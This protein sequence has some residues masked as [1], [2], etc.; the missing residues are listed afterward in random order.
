MNRDTIHEMFM[1]M[2]RDDLKIASQCLN[3][4]DREYFEDSA[5]QNLALAVECPIQTQG[6][7]A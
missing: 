3:K 1:R 5:I 2:V 6:E 7:D 4:T